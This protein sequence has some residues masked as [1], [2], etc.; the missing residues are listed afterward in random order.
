MST[1][2]NQSAAIK[3]EQCVEEDGR[4]DHP[5]NNEVQEAD[6]TKQSTSKDLIT[7]R[8]EK[9]VDQVSDAKEPEAGDGG[10]GW[11]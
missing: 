9:N 1:P 3:R 5:I 4:Q 11:Y 7:E 10:P 8:E 6:T 2:N